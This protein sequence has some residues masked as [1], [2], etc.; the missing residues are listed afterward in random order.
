MLVS[1]SCT[2]LFPDIEASILLEHDVRDFLLL[3]GEC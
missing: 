2:T 1:T 3:Q